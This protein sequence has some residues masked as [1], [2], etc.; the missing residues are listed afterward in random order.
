MKAILLICLGALPNPG[1]GGTPKERLM[2]YPLP[3]R[4]LNVGF[5]AIMPKYIVVLIQWVR[6]NTEF[7]MVNFAYKLSV[8]STIRL[9][10]AH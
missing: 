2:E 4:N 1:L 8:I 6:K 5:A 10:L 7:R 3:M 9:P